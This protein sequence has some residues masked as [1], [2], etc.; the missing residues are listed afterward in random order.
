MELIVGFIDFFI[1][2]DRYLGSL[3]KDFGAGRT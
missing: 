2:L 1:H 3:L